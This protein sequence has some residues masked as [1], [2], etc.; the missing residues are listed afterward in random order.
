VRGGLLGAGRFGGDTE[1]EP[2]G[3]GAS[4]LHALAGAHWFFTPQSMASFYAGGEYR[5]QLTRRAERD[6]GTMLGKAGVEAALSSRAHFFVE[7][8]Y[9]IHLTRGADDERQTRIVGEIGLRIKF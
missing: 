5:A 7:G 2:V 8:G 9:G 6:A 4:A 1:D 3:P